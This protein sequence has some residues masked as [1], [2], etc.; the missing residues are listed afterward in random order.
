MCVAHALQ[1]GAAAPTPDEARPPRIDGGDLRRETLFSGVDSKQRNWLSE[2]DVSFFT[3]GGPSEAGDAEGLSKEEQ[4]VV[5]VGWGGKRAC[6][7]ARS[8]GAG[9]WRAGPSSTPQYNTAQRPLPTCH[10]YAHAPSISCPAPHTPCRSVAS[11]WARW[12]PWG[13]VHLRWCPLA[14]CSCPSPASR[15]SSTLCR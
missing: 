7:L 12:Q 13:W 1:A 10:A 8:S 9:P 5:Q 2:S 3:G 6:T 14:S 11:S 4:A 15:S